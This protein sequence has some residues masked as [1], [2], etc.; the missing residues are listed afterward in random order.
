EYR[1][2]RR[3]VADVE[4]RPRVVEQQVTCFTTRLVEEIDP[5]TRKACTVRKQ[6]PE[7]KTVKVTRY[8]AVP[9]ER[10]VVVRVPVLK[11]VPREVAV[12]RLALDVNTV[13]AIR[14]TYES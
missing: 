14:K 4:L 11:E 10:V 6:V 13:P 7:V 9:V 1:E 2:E 8:E 5:C 12:R 3:T